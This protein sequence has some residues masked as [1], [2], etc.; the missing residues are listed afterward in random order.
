MTAPDVE[1]FADPLLA[2]DASW[3]SPGVVSGA[4]GWAAFVEA[5]HIRDPDG[6]AVVIGAAN[7]S[8]A[9]P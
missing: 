1:P 5:A 4:I 2:S 7:D 9:T 3:I 6:H 8:G